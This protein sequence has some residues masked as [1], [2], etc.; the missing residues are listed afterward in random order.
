MGTRK[1]PPLNGHTVFVTTNTS[2]RRPLFADPRL[3][4]I[5]RAVLFATARELDIA[6][7]AWAI[8]P[9]HVHLLLNLGARDDLP[10]VMQLFKGRSAQ[11]VNDALGR[12]GHVWQ[13]RFDDRIVVHD[14]EFWAK[15][16][17]IHAN[18]V[19]AGL[20]DEVCAYPFSSARDSG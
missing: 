14:R 9:D 7:H 17:Y 4:E 13:R 1:H 15:V 8:M 18:P 20:V 3:A 16:D 10:F 2:G 19:R 11:A 6:I 5:V 12:R